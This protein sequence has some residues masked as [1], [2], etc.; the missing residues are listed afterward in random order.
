MPRGNPEPWLCQ[1]RGYFV[2][3][4]GVQHNLRTA[5]KA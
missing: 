3:L 1:G 4:H 5:D 2:T